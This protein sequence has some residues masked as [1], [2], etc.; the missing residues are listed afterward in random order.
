[1][2]TNFKRILL[3]IGGIILIIVV[4]VLKKDYREYKAKENQEQNLKIGDLS[5]EMFFD[6][7]HEVSEEINKKCPMIIDKDTKLN[8]T[9]VLSNKT[10]QY[11]YTLVN[12]EKENTDVEVLE[13]EFTPLL[14]KDV[15]TNPGLKPFRDRGV[16]LSYYYKD[17]NGDFIMNYK[18]TPELYK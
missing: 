11:N 4:R 5:D 18:V 7:L 16:T 1:M 2:K 10:I 17:K 3:V 9:V 8:N 12:L 15:K 6:F 14:L 13:K